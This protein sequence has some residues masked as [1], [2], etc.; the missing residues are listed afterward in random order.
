MG[1]TPPGSGGLQ[2]RGGPG[3]AAIAAHLQGFVDRG[4]ITKWAIPRQ[5][6]IVPEIPKTSVGKIN[7]RLIREL[8]ASNGKESI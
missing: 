4:H 1:R 8:E 7:K 2:G 3:A 5:I 6:R